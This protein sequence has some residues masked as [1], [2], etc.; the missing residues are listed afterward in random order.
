LHHLPIN[1]QRGEIR[2]QM[3]LNGRGIY[4]ARVVVAG[5]GVACQ[6]RVSFRISL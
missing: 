5:S 3:R 4:R 6:Q 1:A 2:A